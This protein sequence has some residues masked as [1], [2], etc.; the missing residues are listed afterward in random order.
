MSTIHLS[1]EQP[2]TPQVI[3]TDAQMAEDLRSYLTSELRE[4][5]S[6]Y[7]VGGEWRLELSAY[8]PTVE[9]AIDK[10]LHAKQPTKTRR[11]QTIVWES[12]D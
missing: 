10:F 4:Q 3:L 12:D 1:I 2:N 7:E 11:D 5:P 8:W 9:A 6:L